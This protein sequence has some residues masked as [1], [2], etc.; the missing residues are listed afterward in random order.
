[1][2]NLI[3][4]LQ[5]TVPIF[6]LIVLGI[7]YIRF[8]GLMMISQKKMNTFAFQMC[9]PVLVFQ[10]LAQQDFSKAWNPKY[11]LFCFVATFLCIGISYVLSLFLKDRSLN[12]E[13]M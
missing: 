1:M 3:F 13:F 8:I 2:N 6:L 10:D 9:L 12:G 5:A 7:F 11:V 4:S